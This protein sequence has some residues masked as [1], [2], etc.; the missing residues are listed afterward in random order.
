MF[1]LFLSK[2]KAALPHLRESKGRIILVSSG[3]AATG[4]FGW[5]LYG[6]TKASINHLALTLNKEE[7]EVTTISVQPGMVD[8][9]MQV[10]LR[11]EHG[12]SMGSDAGK[13]TGAFEQG[14]L[15]KPET[16]GHVLAKLALD[17]PHD[18]SGGILR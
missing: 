17:A 13:F 7:P 3:A 14:M 9:D 4:Y 15:L 12:S 2:A 5:G 16:P 10:A 8:T 11:E 1:L 6:S 18:L